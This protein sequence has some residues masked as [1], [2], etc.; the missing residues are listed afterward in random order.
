MKIS[1][2]SLI[3]NNRYS[4]KKYFYSV[5]ALVHMIWKKCNTIPS[6]INDKRNSRLKQTI[7]I[8]YRYNVFNNLSV[9]DWLKLMHNLNI[10]INLKILNDFLNN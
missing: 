2:R 10:K 8:E 9:F 7:E 3:Y 6:I 4:F 1:K 5:L